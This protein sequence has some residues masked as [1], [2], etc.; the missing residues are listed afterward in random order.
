MSLLLLSL[1]EKRIRE[2]KQRKKLENLVSLVVIKWW[3]LSYIYPSCSS[4]KFLVFFLDCS[5]GQKFQKTK[6]RKKNRC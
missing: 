6:G 3:K 2:R 1:K 4:L 5:R